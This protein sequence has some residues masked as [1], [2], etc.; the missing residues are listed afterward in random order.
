MLGEVISETGEAVWASARIAAH[1]ATAARSRI[2]TA[3]WSHIAAARGGSVATEQARMGTG[4]GQTTR[5]RNGQHSNKS[6]RHRVSQ[7]SKFKPDSDGSHRQ[8]RLARIRRAGNR[9]GAGPVTWAEKSNSDPVTR[10]SKEVFTTASLNANPIERNYRKPGTHA[11]D[12][13]GRRA[14]VGDT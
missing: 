14:S 3:A 2:A 13:S 6:N 8:F 4:R 1:F 7:L 12:F 9:Q 11:L 5:G 10:C